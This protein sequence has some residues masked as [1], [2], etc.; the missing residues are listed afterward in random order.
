MDKFI[1]TSAITGAIHTPSMS[2]HLPITPDEIVEDCIRAYDAGAAVVH[3]HVRD[4]KRGFSGQQYVLT[5]SD[6]FNTQPQMYSDPITTAYEG[7]QYR[8]PLVVYDGCGR[9]RVDL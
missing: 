7:Q 9:R 1:V 3:I 4:P 2:P 5:V 6:E 8:Y